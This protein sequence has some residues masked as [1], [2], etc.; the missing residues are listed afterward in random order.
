[1]HHPAWREPILLLAGML[2]E[3]AATELISAIWKQAHSPY[4]WELHRDLLLASAV[5][6]SAP[7]VRSEVLRDL[8]DAGVRLLFDV[9]VKWL[10]RLVLPIGILALLIAVAIRLLP[11]TVWLAP[12]V[13]LVWLLIWSATATGYFLPLRVFLAFPQR[14]SGKAR[15]G[16]LEE[17]LVLAA[18]TLGGLCVQG[19]VRGLKARTTVGA[20]VAALTDLD[21]ADTDWDMRREKAMEVLWQM[22]DPAA[23]GPLVAALADS[24]EYVRKVAAETLGQIGDPAAIGPL[25]ARLADPNSADTD[26]DVREAAAWALGQIGEPAVGSLI[27]ALAHPNSA[28]REV[29]AKALGQIGDPAAVGPLVAALADP[30]SADMDWNVRKAAAWALGQIGDHAAVRPLVAALADSEEYVRKAAAEALGQIGD[31]AAVGPL[32]AALADS[33]E[34]VREAAAEALGQIGDP[35]AVGPLV[36]T[37]ADSKRYVR[38]AAAKALE[39]IADNI[40]TVTFA[41]KALRQL[42]RLLT[43]T[44]DGVVAAAFTALERIAARLTELEINDLGVPPSLFDPPIESQASSFSAL[45]V[46]SA[47]VA[48]LSGIASNILAS[49]LQDH[50]HLITDN[51]RFAIVGGVFVLTLVAGAL[52]TLRLT[53]HPD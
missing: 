31:P 51:A 7:A 41:R 46:L 20:L 47:L 17:Q 14:L 23:V 42:W 43:D 32:V 25:V 12:L 19:L 18:A 9:R 50:L 26:W 8:A 3:Q 4:E 22:S 30:N 38:E 29:A 39:Q 44:E 28:V 40:Q 13:A 52:L 48:A 24:N 6:A 2:D 1:L 53:R 37:L 35:A 16:D 34:Y 27:A 36:A 10:H 21:S 45:I 5:A 11:S 33:N 49:Y 15:H